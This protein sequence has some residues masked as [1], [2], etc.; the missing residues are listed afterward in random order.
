MV[1]WCRT[2]WLSAPAILLGRHPEQFCR[3]TSTFAQPDIVFCSASQRVQCFGGRGAAS[4]AR[5]TA[6]HPHAH[7]SDCDDF[8][9]V[10]FAATELC[11]RYDLPAQVRHICTTCVETQGPVY[12]GI[13]EPLQHRHSTQCYCEDWEVYTITSSVRITMAVSRCQCSRTY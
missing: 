11:E 5:W 13:A 8:N 6:R 12:F 9:V 7:K 2:L 1:V 3:P 4:F 10:S